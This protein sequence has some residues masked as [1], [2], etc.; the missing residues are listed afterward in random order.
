M[1]AAAL[2]SSMLDAYQASITAVGPLHC[3][4]RRFKF[5]LRSVPTQGSTRTETFVGVHKQGAPKLQ[6]L[7]TVFLRGDWITRGE[8][9]L[10]WLPFEYRPSCAAF[11]DN[12][13]LLGHRSG[14]ITSLS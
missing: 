12:L 14:K 8:T 6:P 1:F 11:R 13:L 5:A 7:C 4:A 3:I 2:L 9:S 10:F